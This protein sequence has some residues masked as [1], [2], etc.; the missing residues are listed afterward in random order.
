MTLDLKVCTIYVNVSNG[1]RIEK[2]KKEASSAFHPVKWRLFLVCFFGFDFGFGFGFG[3]L[4]N[5]KQSFLRE[6]GNIGHA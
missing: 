5:L 4:V 6:K 2:L 1:K 3:F